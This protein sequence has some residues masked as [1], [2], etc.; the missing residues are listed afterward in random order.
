ML[1]GRSS[2]IDKILSCAVARS[3][4]LVRDVADGRH[5]SGEAQ[6]VDDALARGHAQDSAGFRRGERADRRHELAAATAEGLRD[7]AMTATFKALF[8]LG[9]VVATPG[10]LDALDGEA[11][12]PDDRI[13]HPR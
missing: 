13:S 4:H 2:R 5:R 3:A 6:A 7:G 9:Q 1:F 11:L 12:L 8:P 10:A